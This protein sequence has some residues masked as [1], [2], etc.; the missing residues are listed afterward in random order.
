[1]KK[2]ELAIKYC[3]F[4]LKSFNWRKKWKRDWDNI[5]FCS[6]RCKREWKSKSHPIDSS[7]KLVSS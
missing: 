2:S 5:I 7:L 6:K 4:C 1:M 3:K